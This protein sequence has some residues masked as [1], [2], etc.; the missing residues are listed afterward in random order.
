MKHSAAISTGHERTLEIAREVLHEGGNAFDAAIAAVFAMFITEP[1]MASAGAGGFA[2]CYTPGCGVEVLDFFTQTPANKVATD[3]KD[4]YPI[5]VNFGGE[6]EEFHIGMA[7]MAVPGMIG[8][9]SEIHSRWGSM[10]MKT[11]VQASAHLRKEGV[12]INTFQALDLGLLEPVFRQAP[13]M[14]SSFFKN[15]RI[16]SE[17]DLLVLPQLQNF[18]EFIAEEGARGFYEGE[19]SHKISK[20]CQEKGGFL[21]RSDFENY[22]CHW[23]KPHLL[24]YLGHQL[25]IPPYPSLGGMVLSL[26]AHYRHKGLKLPATMQTI[27][28]KYPRKEDIVHAACQLY[29][30]PVPK[31]IVPSTR[32]TSHFNILDD[33]G[34]TIALTVSLGE[35]SGYFIPGTDMQMNNM[36]GETY[37]L[38]NGH[39]SWSQN[40]R[41]MSMMC[42]VMALN[43][44]S[45]PEFIGG[46]G[47]AGR[48]PYALTQV[49]EQYFKEKLP[50]DKAINAPRMMFH[51]QKFH[52]EKGHAN[53]QINSEHKLVHW[54][55]TSLFF[56]GVHAITKRGSMV[57]AAGDPRRYGVGEVLPSN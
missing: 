44:A 43:A 53:I 42:P 18:L 4:Y 48:I 39:F 15:D 25:A 10:P 17:G 9:L 2:S 24:P 27:Q 14:K 36:L 54:E 40:T 19:I 26:L 31:E 8:A 29:G 20:D 33:A 32:G 12:R 45:M 28:Q 38:P 22:K 34:N 16:L 5:L 1:C 49:M 41:M 51:D 23:K 35:G 56:G 6:T 50:L 47:G 37:L 13:E 46:S 57:E 3:R 21:T 30:V 52:L 7:S 55:E 11:L